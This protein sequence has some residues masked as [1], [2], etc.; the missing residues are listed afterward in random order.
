MIQRDS[1]VLDVPQG[2]LIFRPLGLK[3]Q[4]LSR[5]VSGPPCPIWSVDRLDRSGDLDSV[6]TEE[7]PHGGSSRVVR[8]SG[9]WVSAAHRDLATATRAGEW[10]ARICPS[11]GKRHVGSARGCLVDNDGLGS[12]SSGGHRLIS[13]MSCK[14]Q[15]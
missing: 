10:L 14:S 9:R 11:A 12:P 13:V 5:S 3:A 2:S 15:L 1:R 6:G 7:A 8:R 4:R